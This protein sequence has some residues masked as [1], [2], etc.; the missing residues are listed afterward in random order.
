[1]SR[2]PRV[3]ARQITD[4]DIG[5]VIDLLTRGFGRRRSRQY[6]QQGLDRLAALARPDGTPKYGYLMESDGAVVG[7]ILLIH[8]AIRTGDVSTIRCNLSSWYVEPALRSHAPLL[9]AQ[10]L[11]RKDI[12]YVN[13]SPA[14]HTL[15]IVE[16]Q[17]FTRYSDGQ[18]FSVAL[19][20][21]FGEARRDIVDL[22]SCPSGLVAASEHDLLSDHARYGCISFWYTTPE[23]AYPFVFAP[24]RLKELVPCVQLIYCRDI[25]DLVEF[26]RPIGAYLASRGRNLILVDSNGPI[27][28]L[29]G[30]YV[31]GL[32]PKYFRG[33]T[34]PRLGDLAY[35]EAALFGM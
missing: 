6:W 25:G 22:D 21:L 29:L 20:R 32:A 11:K 15:P 33:P 14:P 5:G 24:R 16:V 35:T 17:G 2:F 9:I 31:A 19:P 4:A 7:V 8:S 23:R 34:P 1:M 3:R 26:A 30:K 10:A 13:I 18:F 28:G 27:R 12:T